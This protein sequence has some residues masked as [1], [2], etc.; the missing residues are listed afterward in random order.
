MRNTRP[1]YKQ[2]VNE[3]NLAQE[4][5]DT[6]RGTRFW[7]TATGAQQRNS[8]EALSKH[9]SLYT[10]LI[11][12]LSTAVAKLP[13]GS[14]K[15][16]AVVRLAD[17]TVPRLCQVRDSLQEFSW[18]LHLVY[19]ME[20]AKRERLIYHN[21][22]L[23]TLL[24]KIQF[25]DNQLS[26]PADGTNKWSFGRSSSGEPIRLLFEFTHDIGKS[27]ERIVDYL[28]RNQITPFGIEHNELGTSTDNSHLNV[29]RDTAKD[30]LVVESEGNS[31]CTDLITQ[32]DGTLRYVG[33]L[34]VLAKILL[35]IVNNNVNDRK[36]RTP[37][38]KSEIFE[39]L[40]KSKLVY[41]RN[42]ETLKTYYRRIVNGTI[43]V[44]PDKVLY[45]VMLNI[46][47]Y[48]ATTFGRNPD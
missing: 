30:K 6:E 7:S 44:T 25:L 43:L 24:Q 19:Q 40:H 5:L 20:A 28:T 33:D 37:F 16:K 35:D 22:Q 39:L 18:R 41:A 8:K 45:S 10:E 15:S 9:I 32:A 34:K 31:K 13:K 14:S 23:L 47:E 4:Y 11:S 29:P 26:Q 42:P 21:G 12:V 2:N 3:R 36:F 17:S 1:R 46:L 27:H 38:G 48:R